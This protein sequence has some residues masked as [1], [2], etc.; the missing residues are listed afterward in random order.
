MKDGGERE[1]GRE[2]EQVMKKVD[3][4]CAY[5]CI[6]YQIIINNIFKVAPLILLFIA[7]VPLSRP[8]IV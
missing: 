5:A 2:E 7:G 8:T 4:D 3:N 6:I 1:R